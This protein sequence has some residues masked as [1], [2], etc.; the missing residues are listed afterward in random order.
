MALLKTLR[1]AVQNHIESLHQLP[2]NTRAVYVDNVL[3]FQDYVLALKENLLNFLPQSVLIWWLWPH[4]TNLS[5]I[6]WWQAFGGVLCLRLV[7]GPPTTQIVIPSAV[8]DE[9]P[10]DGS[11]DAADQDEEQDDVK[12]RLRLVK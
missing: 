10:D 4:L 2:S 6:S 7:L 8:E 3:N 1:D 12:P 5:P 9:D 11:R